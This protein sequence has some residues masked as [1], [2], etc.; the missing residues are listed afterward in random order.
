MAAAATVTFDPW[1]VHEIGL[2]F[3]GFPKQK[4]KN[5]KTSCRRF[6]D[7]Y[8]VDAA[9]ASAIFADF[10]TTTINEAKIVEPD[11]VYFLMTLHWLKQYP[12]ESTLAGMFGVNE[13]TA[14]TEVGYYSG[15][16]QALKEDKV[17][18]QH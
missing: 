16:M 1:E 5:K 14:R 2:D 13:T 4:Q 8:G 10:Q 18:T 6:R 7:A 17:C 11:L 3:A 15:K 9:T 12:I